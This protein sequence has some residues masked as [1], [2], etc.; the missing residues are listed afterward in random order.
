MVQAASQWTIPRQSLHHHLA[1]RREP[2]GSGVPADRGLSKAHP[3]H[4][5]HRHHRPIPTSKLK[6]SRPLRRN[7][8]NLLP[9]GATRASTIRR[10]AEQAE[11]RGAGAAEVEAKVARAV[12]RPKEQS[13]FT[14]PDTRITM[15]SHGFPW[16]DTGIQRSCAGGRG[17]RC[18]RGAGGERPEHGPSEVGS[19]V[20]AAR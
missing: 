8:A 14:G 6:R 17:Q 2:D 20:G 16:S 4:I 3:P 18:R 15:S 7:R 5:T 13:N 9:I 10:A 1:S 19:R 12:P 11:R